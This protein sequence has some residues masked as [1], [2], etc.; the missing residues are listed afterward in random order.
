MPK[1]I[2]GGSAI[3]RATPYNAIVLYAIQY[4]SIWYVMLLA[5][6]RHHQ[7]LQSDTVLTLTLI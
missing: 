1:V 6:I 5:D 4:H 3:L 2:L 7:A